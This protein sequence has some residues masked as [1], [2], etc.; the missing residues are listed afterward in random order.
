MRRAVTLAATLVLA[1]G[2][3]GGCGS[4]QVGI[5]LGEIGYVLDK[6]GPPA[7]N[8]VYADPPSIAALAQDVRVGWQAPELAAALEKLPADRVVVTHYYDACARDDPRL[9]RSGTRVRVDYGRTINR[10][11]VRPADTLAFVVVAG[12]QLPDP[13]SFELCRATIVLHAGRAT[14]HGETGM[15]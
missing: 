2:A 14:S 10:Q 11:C 7:A 8:A 3:L 6:H 15:C 9:L 12:G 13:V 1:G 4:G 5:T